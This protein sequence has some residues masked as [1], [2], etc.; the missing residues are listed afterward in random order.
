MYRMLHEAKSTGKSLRYEAF[1]QSGSRI[2]LYDGVEEW[3]A[4]INAYGASKGLEVQ[5]FITSS[6]LRE[7]IEGTPIA[8]EFRKIY[9]CS[10]LYDVDGVAYWPAVAV[11]YTNKTQFIFKINKGIESVYDS[12]RINEYIEEEERPVPFRRMIYFG[13]GTTDIPCMRLVNSRAV[14]RLRSTIRFQSAN[15]K[16]VNGCCRTIGSIMSVRPI[17]GRIG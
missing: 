2:R 1:V 14:G 4:R 6:G 3:F 5:H 11:N 15:A 16:L 10:F 9:A 13:D 8:K 7:M 17:I 12:Q